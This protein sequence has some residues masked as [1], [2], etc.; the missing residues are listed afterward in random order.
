VSW[1][2]D[3]SFN[4]T[5]TDVIYVKSTDGGANW[6]Q[7]V[8]VAHAAGRNECPGCDNITPMITVGPDGKV[9][10]FWLDRAD[11][12][13]PTG[14][15]WFDSWYSSSTDGGTTW[16]PAIKVSTEPQNLN[17]GFPPGSGNAAGDY[18]GLDVSG[19]SVYVAWNDTRL[20]GQQDIL[21]SR[22][23]MGGP[24]VTPTSPTAQPTNT[25]APSATPTYSAPT[26]TATSQ[27]TSTPTATPT[28]TT[29]PIAGCEPDWQNIQ[30]PVGYGFADIAAVSS[31]AAWAVSS[32]T[33]QYWNGTE[34]EVK[35]HL[36]PVPM[37]T[38]PPSLEYYSLRALSVY[39]ATDIW[40]AGMHGDFGGNTFGLVMHWDGAAWT[41][42]SQW[43]APH[44]APQ[45]G[46]LRYLYD[47]K[48]LGPG[49]A[50]T[51]GGSY[52]SGPPLILRCTTEDC[53]ADTPPHNFGPY[54]SVSASSPNDI[55]AVGGSGVS[56][57]AHFDGTSWQQVSTPSTG[58]LHAIV[59]VAPND[60]WAGGDGGLMH[61][62]GT[63]WSPYAG[64]P[65]Q[66]HSLSGIAWNDLWAADSG[67]GV[68]HWD[69]AG[70]TLSLSYTNAYSAVSALAPDNVWASGTLTAHYTEP[71]QFEDVQPN[72]T[73]YSHI[74]TLSCYAIIQGYPCGGAGEPCVPPDERPYFRPNASI[75]RGQLSKVVSLASEFTEPV[76]SSRQTFADVPYG[77]TFWEYIE[78]MASRGIVEGYP[79]G[80]DGE[81]CDPQSRP[82]F[83]PNT[84]TTR[85]QISKI[86]AIAAGYIQTPTTQTFTD[87]PPGSTF[88]V[89]VENLAQ[90]DIMQGYPCG[91]PGEPCDA[92]QRPYF[93]PNNPATRGQV[94]KIVANTFYP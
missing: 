87:V 16:D 26:S 73:F 34:W 36:T 13:P 68:Y 39:S 19:D 33:I 35:V 37:P 67:S 69:G 71:Q 22:G 51:V 94:S 56:L 52:F 62:D 50:I 7:P 59:S 60:A 23:I 80:G 27:V 72:N 65:P 1:T 82:Y 86:T 76:P 47:I 75:T 2:D 53:T 25:S 63:A 92:E 74:Q 14:D 42:V 32:D 18:W 64:G 31:D 41:I 43:A 17:V 49:E 20:N 3:R 6:S 12:P 28:T 45:G 91:G 66:V 10:A 48:A 4:T 81:P 93:R 44:E 11:R 61:W 84:P 15:G 85:G 9:H 5:G 78:R 70:W 21:V 40:A 55:W 57:T 46:T 38:P 89:W 24:S 88:Y 58:T 90:R 79:C 29:T 8:N 54:N 30:H 83:R 77:A